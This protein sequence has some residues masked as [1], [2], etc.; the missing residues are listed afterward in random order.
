M[1]KKSFHSRKRNERK[2]KW[3]FIEEIYHTDMMHIDMDGNKS[4]A[5]PKLCWQQNPAVP[6]NHI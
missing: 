4:I 3:A 2:L 6:H 5:H 1:L